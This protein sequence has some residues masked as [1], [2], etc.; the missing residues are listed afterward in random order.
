MHT[1]NPYTWLD[2][3][4]AKMP[5]YYLP[6][7]PGVAIAGDSLLRAVGYDCGSRRPRGWVESNA[8][9]FRYY[10]TPGDKMILQVREG[11]AKFWVV[12]RFRVNDWLDPSGRVPGVNIYTLVYAPSGRPIWAPT[13][14]A[15][16]HLAQYCHPTFRSPVA[17]RWVQARGREHAEFVA[18]D[19]RYL[20]E[21]RRLMTR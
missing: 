6:E 3:D 1:S 21:W 10:S 11:D 19:E 2:R 7:A 5:N 15:A 18:R 9:V 13:H 16:M 17:G 4:Q 14:Q 12:E 8:G 20:R